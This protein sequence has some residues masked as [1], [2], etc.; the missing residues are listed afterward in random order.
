M[1]SS[2]GP[3]PVSPETYWRRRVFV[4]VGLFV[5]VALITYACT[6]P[7]SPGEGDEASG[8][9]SAPSP[10]P[11]ES[12][13]S[14]SP[15]ASPSAS[16]SPSAGAGQDGGGGGEGG[17]EGGGTGSAGGDSGDESGGG[18][19]DGGGSGGSEGVAA[20]E[21]PGDPCR[22][23][24]VVVTVKTDKSDYDWNDK[25]KFKLSL[26]NT[27]DQTCT[28][29]VGPESLELRVTSGDDRIFSTGDCAGGSSSDK[30]K[31]QRGVPYTTTVTWDRKRSWKDCPDRNVTAKR[32]GTYVVQ[33]HSK[34]DQN[35]EP[36]VFRLN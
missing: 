12:S 21:E 29:D 11:E 32:P 27:E 36:Q 7:S 33:L 3:G 17:G 6:R 20:P 24:D 35:A 34:Y 2:A 26:V 31:L 5:V 18:S 19:G 14:V 8:T 4:L 22:P 28:V 16:P 1:A 10:T 9:G 30:Q 23:S 15:P 13:P 25:P